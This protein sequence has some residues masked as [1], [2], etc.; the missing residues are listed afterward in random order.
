MLN[1]LKTMYMEW[2]ELVGLI[3]FVFIMGAAYL[4]SDTMPGLSIGIVVVTG[5]VALSSFTEG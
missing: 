2:K 5:A 1:K 4:L 3:T